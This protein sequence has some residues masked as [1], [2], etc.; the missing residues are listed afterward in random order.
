MLINVNVE[1]EHFQ[2]QKEKKLNLYHLKTRK[3]RLKIPNVIANVTQEA[4]LKKSIS[5]PA[6]LREGHKQT[7]ENYV[8]EERGHSAALLR[9]VRWEC[10]EAGP[11]ELIRNCMLLQ[12][13]L[14]G[15]VHSCRRRH[16]HKHKYKREHKH[17]CI[18]IQAIVSLTSST[19]PFLVLP[20]LLLSCSIVI[21]R[22]LPR[23][24]TLHNYCLHALHT[25]PSY[26]KPHG[27]CTLTRVLRFT[28]LRGGGWGEREGCV[29]RGV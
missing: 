28:R 2:Y 23:H 13:H 8:R 26:F 21:I 27:C 20:L 14:G 3:N 1:L 7:R 24:P 19:P 16:T 9:P 12:V 15:G 6:V 10:E 17:V 5:I 11:G 25:Q 4:T 29:E 22:K 18:Y